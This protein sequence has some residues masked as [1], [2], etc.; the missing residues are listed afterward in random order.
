MLTP[1]MSDEELDSV[2]R[3]VADEYPQD[4]PPPGAWERLDT[5]LATA[6]AT[7]QLRRKVLRVFGVE[8]A[9]L[10]VLFWLAYQ[11]LP[12]LAQPSRVSV[13]ALPTT[14]ARPMA[15]DGHTKPVATAASASPLATSR[16]SSSPAAVASPAL[17]DG[18]ATTPASTNLATEATS[19]QHSASPA[20]ER[21]IGPQSVTSPAG[22]QAGP[23][24]PSALARG[25]AS[26]TR[27]IATTFEVTTPTSS[28]AGLGAAR[29][30]SS[31]TPSFNKVARP[32]L[33]FASALGTARYR[34]PAKAA[35]HKLALL[36]VAPRAQGRRR[37]RNGM[38][39]ARNELELDVTKNAGLI[40]NSEQVDS[41]KHTAKAI[42]EVQESPLT[43]LAE[44]PAASRLAQLSLAHQ[45]LPDSLGGLARL[46]PT[47]TTTEQKRPAARPPYRVVVGLLGAPSFSAVRTPQ[48]A[49]LGGDYGLTLEYLLTPRLRV[50]AGLISSQKNYRAASTDYDA[51]AAWQW[52][53]GD[54]MLDANCRITEIPLDLRY[55][56]LRRPTY[57]LFTSVGV[58]SLL[59]RNERY[60]YDWTMNGQ[61]FTKSAQVINGSNHFLG[62]LNL[63]V[64]V[65]RPI[66]GR[67]SAQ[68][69]PFWQI[70]LGGVG[71]G[72]VRLSS[73]GA[74]F[75]LKFGL[76]R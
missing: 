11:L 42:A 41:K 64:G 24:V 45:A 30:T 52:F 16:T 72:H 23:L 14:T 32:A 76:I 39:A 48:T 34:R 67:W 13:A 37:R 1:N 6:T 56:V 38:S 40:G 49:Q 20:T 50:R 66:G 46:L 63:S 62:V 53:A 12:Q 28:T 33:S 65:E 71:A 44:A 25:V 4:A 74:S 70:P 57:A 9:T 73:A 47:D 36:N 54:Y 10:A 60:S 22:G 21:A 8:V 27:P 26:S 19:R 75:S 31:T 18:P 35:E 15:T 69:E 17:A 2:F 68:V 61:T 7:Q 58:N 55:D 51:P 3:R 29:A 59:M 5:Q 43:H